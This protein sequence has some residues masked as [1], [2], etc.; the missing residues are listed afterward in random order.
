MKNTVLVF[1]IVLSSLV[2]QL[3]AQ[4]SSAELKKS[5]AP[6][7]YMVT[8]TNARPR[9]PLE[10]MIT[11]WRGIP[12]INKW[13][14]ENFQ[15]DFE[16]AKRL[17]ENSPT[18]DSTHIYIPSELYTNKKGVCIDLSRFAV[19]VTKSIDS[20]KNVKYLMIEFEP[21]VINNMTLRKHWMAVY[22]EAGSFYFFADSKR[23][24]YISGPYSSSDAFIKD[25]ELYRD[26]KIISYKILSDFRKKKKMRS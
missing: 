11:Q 24:G 2:Q 18:R 14:K 19:E 8:G 25:Y 4:V 20:S 21:V 16:R 12:D 9:I 3:R 17:A 15:Y 1:L 22:E 13:I 5:D 10:N 7:T 23:P 26:R 6:D